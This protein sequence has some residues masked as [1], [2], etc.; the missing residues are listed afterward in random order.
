MTLSK[1]ARRHGGFMA[2]AI[3]SKSS[4]AF[5]VSNLPQK[6][7]QA[8]EEQDEDLNNVPSCDDIVDLRKLKDKNE[9]SQVVLTIAQKVLPE[10]KNA[11]QVIL[12][13]VSGAMTNA[14]YFMSAPDLPRVLLRVYGIGAD[15]IVDRQHE[16]EWLARLSTMSTTK[17]P[18]L[19]ATFGNG[20][21][22]E[23]LE[24]TTLTHADL[25]DPEMSCQIA[26]SLRQLHD[27]VQDYPPP[28]EQAQNG[29]STAS[30]RIETWKN[31]SQWYTYMREELL[32][33]EEWKQKL[34]FLQVD[35]LPREIEL[36]KN[37]IQKYPSPII[38]AHNDTQYG[39]VLQ[40]EKTG[41]LVVVDF[42][43]A[44]YNPRG[45]DI[46]N[47]FCEWM[48]DYHGPNPASMDLDQFPTDE[49]QLR[50][51]TAYIEA[52]NEE[53]QHEEDSETKINNMTKDMDAKTLQ[54]EVLR[55][56]MV[57]HLM[58]ALWGLVQAS[59]SEIDFDYFHYFTQRLQ[60]FR[61]HLY[62]ALE[63]EEQRR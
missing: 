12:D 36:C 32:T 21:F 61:K 47:H 28:E 23:Y 1:Q 34:E 41:E 3:R 56:I 4:P 6:Q 48:Y 25:H 11:T 62:E 15:Q 31:I 45:F 57:P 49:E 16:L 2:T 59:Q 30:F 27:V 14:V 7:Q 46:A 43:Y 5:L 38:F 63:E 60:R 29:D 44:G 50:F 20:R 13:R 8:N 52:D 39:N 19:L 17:S 40:L 51:L 37:Y 55:W 24:S 9:L 42:E 53:E 58:W 10:W 33:Q 22:E 18:Q 54:Q 26:R 35:K